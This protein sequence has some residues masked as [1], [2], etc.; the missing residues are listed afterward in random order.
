MVNSRQSHFIATPFCSSRRAFT[1]KGHTLSRSYGA[2]L[3]SSL[4][5]VL[6][7]ALEFSSHPPESVYGTGNQDCPRGAFLGSMGSLSNIASEDLM[8]H[9]LSTLNSRF[10]PTNPVYGL[11]LGRPEPSRATLLRPPSLQPHLAGT[12]ILTCFPSPTPLGLGL[13]PG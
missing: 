9:H 12:G 11:R 3:Q 7:S 13:G 6:S 5:T 1:Y 10:Y 8:P 4:T 2:I